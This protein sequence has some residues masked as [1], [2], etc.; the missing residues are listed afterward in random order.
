MCEGAD[1]HFHGQIH[2]R[3]YFSHEF[4]TLEYD[5]R[6]WLLPLIPFARRWGAERLNERWID[7]APPYTHF[8]SRFEVL[9]CIHYHLSSHER[10]S[11][12]TI[13]ERKFGTRFWKHAMLLWQQNQGGGDF[14]RSRRISIIQYPAT[15]INILLS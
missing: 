10:H 7:S 4:A 2:R 9:P 13:L 1:T 15:N 6:I 14:K 11:F 3:F 12:T 8:F 5:P